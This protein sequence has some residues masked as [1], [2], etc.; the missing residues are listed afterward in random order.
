MQ[1]E[2]WKTDKEWF[3]AWFNHPAYHVLYGHRSESE[4]EQ[5][6]QKL[7][8]LEVL[9]GRGEV[10]EAGCGSGRHARALHALGWKVTAFDLSPES[11][12]AAKAQSSPDIHFQVQD[13]RTLKHQENWEGRFHLVTNLFT[14]L[15]YF[16]EP[17]DQRA[18]LDGL[19]HC[20]HDDGFVVIDYLNLSL[21]KKHLV[22]FERTTKEGTTFEIHR[23]I[24]EGW[25]E[26][27]IAFEW[28]GESQHHVERVLAWGMPEFVQALEVAGLQC[29]QSWGDYHLNSWSARSPRCI[30]LAQPKQP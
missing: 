23:R 15:G 13:L 7:G 26:K 3:K 27:S 8:A 24:H 2:V 18:V 28:M 9:K 22:P 20:L 4:A 5:F 10:L 25:I 30:M 17:E 29:I 6:V 14:S 11:I 16:E 1:A 19:R 12:S 21:V